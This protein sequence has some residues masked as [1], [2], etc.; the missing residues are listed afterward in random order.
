[1]FDVKRYFTRKATWVKFGHQTPD[2][3]TSSYAGVVSRESICTLLTY[4]ALHEVDVMAADIRN[5]YL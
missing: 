5:V 2:T 4:G 1:M 3:E